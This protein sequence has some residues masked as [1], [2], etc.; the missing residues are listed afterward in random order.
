MKK[1]FSTIWIAVVKWIER[2]TVFFLI[3]ARNKT[4]IGE[5]NN[6]GYHSPFGMY[7]FTQSVCG[8]LKEADHHR[9]TEKIL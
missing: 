4:P 6:C 7:L 5:Q 1:R 8:F 3:I 9:Q 2:R